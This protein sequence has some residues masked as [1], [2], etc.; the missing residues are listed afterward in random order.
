MTAITVETGKVIHSQVGEQHHGKTDNSQNYPRTQPVYFRERLLIWESSTL[1][2]ASMVI[3]L[4][5][6]RSCMEL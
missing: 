4:Y 5:V 2:E 3:F 1:Y 6:Y